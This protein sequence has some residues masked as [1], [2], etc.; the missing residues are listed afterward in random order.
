MA[1]IL[2]LTTHLSDASKDSVVHAADPAASVEDR[3]SAM[4][5]TMMDAIF[6]PATRAQFELHTAARID[7]ALAEHLHQLNARNAEAYVADL[8][9]ALL[10]ANVPLE[11]V[12]AAMEL[13][14]C[15]IVGLSLLSI[16]GGDPEIEA[17]MVASLRSI[18]LTEVE[19]AAADS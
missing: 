1:L 17:R 14:V 5:Q 16:S 13:A 2:A 18:L 4:V 10:E 8:A 3:V 7:P 19:R 9:T 15:A 6:E 12:Q 11:R